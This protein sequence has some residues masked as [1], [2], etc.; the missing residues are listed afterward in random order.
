[1]LEL[2]KAHFDRVMPLFDVAQPNSTMIFSTL[3]GRT[4]G[5]A[6]VDDINNPTSC[7]LVMD[8]QNFSFTHEAVDQQW[9][10][11]TMVG[12][13]PQFGLYLNW[14]PQC[15]ATLQPPPD[16]SRFIAGYEFVEYETQGNLYLPADRYLC[17][18]DAD[19]LPYCTW[20]K[21]ILSA[22]GTIENFLANGI[23]IGVMKGDEICSEAYAIFFGAGKFE[24]G[25]VTSE[26]HRQQGN[27]YLACKGLLETLEER[28]YTPHWSY[29]EG[30]VA[31]AATARKLGF[32]AQRAYQWLYYAQAK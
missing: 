31:S 1:M 11:A 18:I 8:F 19:L 26:K 9:L 30:N 24:I 3:E 16:V 21:L 6:Y 27:G 22:F 29:F 23:G 7:L 4:L 25:I 15:A 5:K 13:R 20:G 12:L 2:P 32:K 28:G 10:N 17:R 14:S